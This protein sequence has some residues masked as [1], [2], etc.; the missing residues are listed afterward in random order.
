MKQPCDVNSDMIN[1]GSACIKALV[2]S[3]RDLNVEETATPM[4]RHE[5]ASAFP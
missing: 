3:S 5:W 2:T 1:L 4:T